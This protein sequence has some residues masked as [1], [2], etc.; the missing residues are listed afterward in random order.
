MNTKFRRY[1]DELQVPEYFLFD[2][3]R[4][5]VE[6]GLRGYV[7]DRSVV[8]Y[9]FARREATGRRVS[10]GWWVTARVQEARR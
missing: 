9:P 2:S 10:P 4:E 7:L 6:E 1:R 3:R 8:L 5:W